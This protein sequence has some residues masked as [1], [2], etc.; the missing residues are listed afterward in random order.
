[1]FLFENDVHLLQEC[2]FVKI[3]NIRLC[4]EH[5]KF[6]EEQNEVYLDLINRQEES[7]LER[8]STK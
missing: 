6:S 4:L 8:F 3:D 2:I 5:K 7:V 1:M